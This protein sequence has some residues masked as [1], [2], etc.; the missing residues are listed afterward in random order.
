MK[1]FDTL[2]GNNK[3]LSSMSEDL[4]QRLCSF[5]ENMSQDDRIIL[6][7]ALIDPEIDIYSGVI[8]QIRLLGQNKLGSFF[9]TEMVSIRT[10]YERNQSQQSNDIKA[11]LSIRL[12]S[13]M[14]I[15]PVT[16]EA[17]YQ[18]LNEYR[19]HT[20]DL[21]K[22]FEKN[23]RRFLGTR[24]RINRIMQA[25]LSSDPGKFSLYNNGITMVASNWYPAGDRKKLVIVNPYIVNSCQ[26]T[27]TI[28]N[29]CSQKLN[30]GGTAISVDR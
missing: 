30:S 10:I 28:W 18:M 12:R 9:D 21:D 26:T 6:L 15:A 11:S 19:N 14:I 4:V 27:R 16:I 8:D 23:V 29:V 24:G 7:F 17:I 2:T 13:Q 3:K 20:S 5:R 25:T 22:I 1:I